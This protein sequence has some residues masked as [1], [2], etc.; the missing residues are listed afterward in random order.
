VICTAEEYVA[1]ATSTHP[2]KHRFGL[3]VATQNQEHG[4]PILLELLQPVTGEFGKYQPMPSSE[5]QRFFK[6]ENGM[7]IAVF[8]AL[9]KGGKLPAK[10][11]RQIEAQLR[12]LHAGQPQQR[13]E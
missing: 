5:K 9:T 7:V 4:G 3:G 10:V 2:K 11:V 12:Q 6:V 8:D 13:M 1:F